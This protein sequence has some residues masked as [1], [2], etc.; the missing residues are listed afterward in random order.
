MINTPKIAFEVDGRQCTLADFLAANCDD[1]DVCNWARNARPG[2][3]YPSIVPC[4]AI[5]PTLVMPTT[6]ELARH[7]AAALPTV[8]AICASVEEAKAALARVPIPTFTIGPKK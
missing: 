8:R 7:F 1:E 5:T 3:R 4:Q 2:D 6:E